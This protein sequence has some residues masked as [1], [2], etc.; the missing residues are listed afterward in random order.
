MNTTRKVRGVSTTQSRAL[1]QSTINK[2]AAGTLV[3]ITGLLVVAVVLVN[4]AVNAEKRAYVRQA[5]FKALG[6]QLQNASDY[7]T[8]EARLYAVTTDHT[9]LDNYW[10]E[11][12]VTKTRDK[13]LAQLEQLDATQDELALVDQAKTNSDALVKTES[14]SQR[15][16][17]ETTG[18]APANM[19][20]AIAQTQLDAADEAL[21]PARKLEVARTIMFDAK[22]AADKA[23]IAAPMDKFQ[24]MLNDRAAQ[25][26]T[27][28]DG[29]TSTSMNLLI[30]LTVVLPVAIGGV[31]F[32]L[33]SKVGRVIVRYTGA[34]R[35]RD[36]D[37][38]TFRLDPTGTQ[39]LRALAETFNDELARKLDMVRAVAGNAD[40]LA[41]AS[42]ELAATSEQVA[43]SA[44]QASSQAAVVSGSAEQVAR[45]V[46]IVAAGSEEMGASIREIAE[47]ANEAA[48]VGDNAVRLAESTNH[49]VAKLGESSQE[50]GNVIKVITSIAEQTNLLA[51]NAT[52]EAARA[53]DAGKGFAVVASEVK[54]LAQE[55]A[56]ATEDIA[57]RIAAIQTDSQGAVEAIAQITQVIGKINDFQT[58]IASAVEEQTATTNE[59]NRSVTD[60]ATGSG[61][62]AANISGV[63]QAAQSAADGIAEAKRA[64]ADLAR[65]GSELQTLI[66]N[67]RY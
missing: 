65:M 23:V 5:E 20:P 6:L 36:H 39:E 18:V 4:S 12:T 66:G 24:K 53:G 49:T 64:T 40:A 52:I 30:A 54:D 46:Q 67:Y 35:S 47:N 19:P 44:E 58:T 42:Q 63:A 45:N 29:S 55:T 51:L 43:T 28:A 16:V 48:R 32:L 41:S 3:L 56:K 17:L 33:Q 2:A 10:N 37:D 61:D 38:L 50:I 57:S 21:S 62:I 11:I 27:S 13:A 1:R 26:V 60:A 8:D 34:L 9:H 22:Y 31:L 14:R 25:A 15:L 59:M 7:L